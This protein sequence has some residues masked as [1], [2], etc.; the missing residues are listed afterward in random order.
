MKKILTS[1]FFIAVYIISAYSQTKD[2]GLIAYYKFDNIAEDASIYKNDGVI[3]GNIMP[4]KDRF[5]IDCTAYQFD[6]YSYIR[7]EN[8]GALKSVKDQLT[9]SVWATL[10]GN[11]S[12]YPDWFTICCKSDLAYEDKESPHFR[13]QIT[14]NTISLNTEI[15]ESYTYNYIRDKW[16]F[17]TVTYDKS[18]LKFYINGSKVFQKNINLDLFDN[19]HAL[20]IGRD[21]P[22]KD[23]YFCGAL[24]DLRIYNRTLSHVEINQ[25][26]QDS[27]GSLKQSPCKVNIDTIHKTIV[28]TDTIR[29]KKIIS[30]NDT[31]IKQ[32]VI[33]DTIKHIVNDTIRKNV[34]INNEPVDFQHTIV[35]SSLHIEL[36]PY[37]DK[38]EDKDTVSIYINGQLVRDKYRIKNR[39]RIDM[40][41]DPIKLKLNPSIENILITKAWNTGKIPPNTLAVD[42]IDGV[43]RIRK[44]VIHSDIGM[45]G[46][47]KFIYKPK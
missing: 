14:K 4:V 22:G 46:G 32:I 23:E 42:I 17:L 25:L 8:N 27:S 7:V 12:K 21:K 2:R 28:V 29:S 44:I 43:N 6:G 45:N 11:C 37:D 40:K 20:T 19:N 33:Y 31:V 10:T 36:I 30:V 13:F 24:D 34:I 3:F 39:N 16:Y 35:V 5:G 41:K 26:Y 47:V 15:V 9:I 38:T 1:I 18:S